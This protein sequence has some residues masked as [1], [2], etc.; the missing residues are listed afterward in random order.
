M[1]PYPLFGKRLM[2]ADKRYVSHGSTSIYAEV[3]GE[4]CYL[5]FLP[6][7]FYD[8]HSNDFS[9]AI[10]F[11]FDIFNSGDRDTYAVLS[12]SYKIG[13]KV[14]NYVI[15]KQLVRKD[16]MNYLCFDVDIDQAINNG[17]DNVG[18]IR[19]NFDTVEETQSPLKLYVDN[20]RVRED[21]QIALSNQTPPA[22]AG[23]MLCSF[24]GEYF[25]NKMIC[26]VWEYIFYTQFPVLAVNTDA[27]YVTEGANSLKVTR[28]AQYYLDDI[29]KGFCR[30]FLPSECFADIDFAAYAQAQNEICF[31]VYNDYGYNIDITF[32]VA[33]RTGNSVTVILEPDSWTTVK[34]DISQIE[35]GSSTTIDFMFCE[36]YDSSNA[37]MY[38]DN[39]RFEQKEEAA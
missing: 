14:Y 27:M 6:Q 29:Y 28:F 36:Y 3:H 33:S 11:L 17:I 19:L 25:K 9:K 38:I 24:E 5:A 37:V 16:A 32:N 15:G 18:E 13:S 23:N 34:L 31:D 12:L 30:F 7:Y 35:W 4:N 10:S 2:N 21:E 26:S 1:I 20:F 22:V 8:G 39:L